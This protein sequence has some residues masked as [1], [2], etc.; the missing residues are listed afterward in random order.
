MKR[1][2]LINKTGI[3]VEVSA[4]HVH[5]TTADLGVLYGKGAKLSVCKH[6]SQPGQFVAHERVDVIGINGS[7]LNVAVLGPCR[8]RSQVEISLTDARL[9]GI[10]GVIRESGDIDG[11]PGC[12]L[13][14]PAGSVALSEGVIA[15]KRHLH[16]TPEDA[17]L[18]QVRNGQEI[19]LQICS[20][21]RSVDF[22]DVRVRV[23]DQFQTAVHIDTDEANACGISGKARAAI[24][25]Q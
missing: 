25:N 10:A 4:R 23:S 17:V 3:L 12:V 8:S 15:A 19:T 13:Q 1:S 14:G 21:Q 7:L 22:H 11:T 2:D 24:V 5:L 18:Y 16:I 6:L 9:L 20:E